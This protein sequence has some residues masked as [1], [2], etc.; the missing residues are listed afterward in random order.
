[1]ARAMLSLILVGTMLI[2]FAAGA[3]EMQLP[4]DGDDFWIE[5]REGWWTD[6]LILS[7]GSGGTEALK[8]LAPDALNWAFYEQPSFLNEIGTR[9]VRAAPWG[10]QE[11]E[12][13]ATGDLADWE[14]AG[15]LAYNVDDEPI[16]YGDWGGSYFMDPHSEPW[17]ELIF[18]GIE[19]ALDGADGVSQDN[20]G[21]PPF[22][23]GHG[24]FSPT[25]K[26]QFRRFLGKT[27]NDGALESL[28]INVATFDIA[29]YLRDNGHVN[30]NPEAVNDP[31]YRAFVMYQYLS[32]L[33]IWAEIVD[34]LHLDT[35]PEK[36]VH[37][38]QYGVW[39][40]YDSNP[41]SVLLSQQHQVVEIEYVSYL[42]SMPPEVRDSL[43]YK[44]GLASGRHEKPVWIRGIVY[45]W[46][47]GQSVLR[48]NHLRYL[49]ASAYANG[50]IRTLELWHGTPHGQE[51]LS[52]DATASL[53]QY[54][55]WLDDVR[56]LFERKTSAANV[57]VVYSIPTM[58]WRYFPASGHWNSQQVASI[59][60]IAHALEFEHIPYDVIAFG[61]PSVWWDWDLAEQLRQYDLLILP[62]VD[63]LLDRQLEALET[64]VADGGR[65]LCTGDFG[66]HDENLEPRVSWRVALLTANP[67]V[68]LLEGTPGRELFQAILAGRTADE[69]YDAIVDAVD[70]LLGDAVTLETTAPETITVNA[71]R[72][73]GLY[74]VHLLNQDYDETADRMMPSDAFELRLRIPEDATAESLLPA[75]IF[76]DDGTSRT[77][78]ADVHNGWIVV[79]I[80]S[81]RFH[82]IVGLGELDDAAEVAMAECQTAL[83]RNPW[84]SDDPDI[85]SQLAQFGV[86]QSSGEWL[87]ILS[88][89]ADLEDAIMASTPSVAYDFAHWQTMAL[90]IESARSIDA[91]HPEWH[92]AKGL[93]SYVSEQIDRAPI[94]AETLAGIS[95]LVIAPHRIG[96]SASEIEAIQQF[97]QAGG[98]LLFIGDGGV[99]SSYG[100]IT[101]PFGLEFVPYSTL[102]A[103]VHLWDNVSFDVFD[104]IEHP[105]TNGV[106]SI[107]LNF[108]APMTVDEDWQVVAWTAAAVWEES[109]G[110]GGPFPVVAYRTLGS[111]RI[112]A[113]CDNA[114]FGDW[115]NTSLVHNLVSW[116]AGPALLRATSYEL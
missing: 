84:A 57:G 34:E 92:V 58:L 76:H 44:I 60:G 105:I 14:L 67:N 103:E 73:K 88:L 116:L 32:N 13:V 29:A 89:C 75:S 69:S 23:K 108:S 46:G 107:Q 110:L 5:A 24:G 28:D 111:G 90:D 18:D 66:A 31:V 106:D 93:A 26:A 95:V 36:I 114:P 25:E 12:E 101:S 37:G 97:V 96:F 41:Y 109:D 6:V 59:S 17:I 104:I 79:T 86:A 40:P 113:V 55:D 4:W 70:G 63:C 20:I 51:R 82:S 16:Y 94:S 61:H 72:T 47:A 87:E 54:Y 21:V 38:N 1:M 7:D 77:L 85:A 48:T 53:L 22:I 15:S 39:S 11:S 80:P 45:D 68:T 115:G 30:G 42:Q 83:E 8:S 10:Y 98:G 64:F 65:L 74:T 62:D 78:R 35:S 2:G 112:A 71:Y 33:E 52:E 19:D 49:T 9:H 56:F 43:L 27:F 91:E 3:Q 99:P 81:V 50:A 100:D 102:T